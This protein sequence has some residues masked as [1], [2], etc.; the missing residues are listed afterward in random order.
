MSRKAPH[1]RRGKEARGTIHVRKADGHIEPFSRAKLRAS[2]RRSQVPEHVIE[3]VEREVERRLEREADP[4]PSYRVHRITFDLL[5]RAARHFAARYN[6]KRA[7]RQLGPTGFPFE[8]FWAKVLEAEGY[9]VE[10]DRVLP[11]RCVEHEVDV[12]ARRG[13]RTLISE[14]KFHHQGGVTSDVKVAL[15]IQA[16]RLDLAAGPPESQHDEFWLVTSTR[17]TADAVRYGECVGL[18][19][20]AW[21]YPEG[22]SLQDRI[23]RNRVYPVTML[24]TL[25]LAQKQQLLAA[26]VVL[27]RQIAERPRLLRP[28][29][30]EPRVRDRVVSEARA[31]T[32]GWQPPAG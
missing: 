1:S 30:L 6:L 26:G 12:I 24:T 28:L 29:R 5:R 17:F 27:C 23:E 4:V 7:I 9:D 15:Y 18:K 19:L 32:D 20:C 31:V 16:R 2:L 25:T 8:R 11:G 22:A 14:C 21:D 3:R 13:G 10:L